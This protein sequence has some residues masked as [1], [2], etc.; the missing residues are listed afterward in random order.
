[1]SGGKERFGHVFKPEGRNGGLD[2]VRVDECHSHSFMIMETGGRMVSG[3]IRG[4]TTPPARRGG[5][6]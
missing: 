5:G 3:S 6:I 4:S 1:V 2:Q